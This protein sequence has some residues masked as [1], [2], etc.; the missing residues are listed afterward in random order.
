[1]S[2]LSIKRVAVAVSIVILLASVLPVASY[3]MKPRLQIRGQLSHRDLAGILRAHREVC[4]EGPI[5]GKWRWLPISIEKYVS[6]QLNPIEIIAVPASGHATIVYRGFYHFYYDEK[7]KHRWGTATYH[8]S[9]E[10]GTWFSPS[11]IR[12]VIPAS[13]P[14]TPML[15]ST[16]PTRP[17]SRPF[18]R[19]AT[20][21]ISN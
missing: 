15:Q 3:C 11:P 6:S 7:G 1:M 19:V 20:N 17:I 4:P 18:P 2:R 9:K 5:N 12:P 10:R 13:W 16:F 14:S 21:R 8:L